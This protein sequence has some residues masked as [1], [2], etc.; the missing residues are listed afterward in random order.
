MSSTPSALPAEWFDQLR[1]WPDVEA[2][3]LQASDATDRLLLAEAAEQIAASA[4][5]EVVVLG[6]T[7]GA[8][9]LGARMLGA[10][11]VRVWTDALVAEQ[12]IQANAMRLGLT[13]GWR[14]VALDPEE[15]AGARIVLA[16]LPRSLDQLRLLVDLVAA[17]PAEGVQVYCGGR[18]KHMSLSMNDVLKSRFGQVHASLAHQKSRLL[19]ASEPLAEDSTADTARSAH[20]AS[21]ASAAP[22]PF[23]EAEVDPGHGIASITVCAVPGA[24]AGASLDIGTRALLPYLSQAAQDAVVRFFKQQRAESGSSDQRPV[25]V[26]LGCGTG[27]IATVLAQADARLRVIATDQLS[28]AVASARLTAAANGLADRIEVRRDVLLNE[29]EDDSVDLVACNPP[30]HVGAAV[31]T[32]VALEMFE[33]AARVLRPGGRLLTVFNSHLHYAS[34]LQRIVGPT[35]QLDRN[36]KFTVTESR[37]R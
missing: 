10:V 23:S 30:F 8:L 27:I 34:D 33:E 19:L 4:P 17:H 32:G 1:R 22:L 11:D 24:F 7:H 2:D 21:T 37:A 18:V 12:A 29:M 14:T 20:S 6:D 9:T 5:G 25:A 31:H 16:Q 35:R 15:F 3:N 13:D 36:R 26:D 28:S